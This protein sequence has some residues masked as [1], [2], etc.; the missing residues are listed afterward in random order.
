MLAVALSA[1]LVLAALP[2]GLVSPAAAAVIKVDDDGP[3]D[4]SSVAEAVEAA[5]DGDRIA[6]APGR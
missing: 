1:A 2:G 5:S 3:A 6:V 4:F